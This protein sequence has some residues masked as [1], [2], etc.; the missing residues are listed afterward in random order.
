MGIQQ[1]SPKSV[2]KNNIASKEDPCRSSLTLTKELNPNAVQ[3]QRYNWLKG[4]KQKNLTREN[5][6]SRDRLT[7]NLAQSR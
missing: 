4:M 7:S 5:M 2:F 6:L 3:K 1:L